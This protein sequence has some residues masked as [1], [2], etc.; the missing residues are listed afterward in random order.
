MPVFWDVPRANLTAVVDTVDWL[1]FQFTYFRD[2]KSSLAVLHF[3]NDMVTH[4][5][6]SSWVSEVQGAVVSRRVT[7]CAGMTAHTVI[8][9]NQNQLP[10]WWP[11]SELSSLVSGRGR[12]SAG[13]SLWTCHSLLSLELVTVRHYGATRYERTPWSRYSHWNA[14]VWSWP[15]VQRSS[16]LLFARE[17][18]SDFSI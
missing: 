11:T 10:Y 1:Q 4:F 18:L 14:Y 12:Y 3:Q 17:L 5:K 9:A 15:C 16:Q 13:R 8:V 7:T 2:A 6:A